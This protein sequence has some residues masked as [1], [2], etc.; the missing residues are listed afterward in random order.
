MPAKKGAGEF[1]KA[2]PNCLSMQVTMSNRA[3]LTAY[4]ELYYRCRECGFEAKIFPEFALNDLE[5][6]AKKKSKKEKSVKKRA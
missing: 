5:K 3:A 2:C 1:V 6:L 4:R